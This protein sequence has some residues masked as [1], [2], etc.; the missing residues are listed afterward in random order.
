MNQIV[1]LT[2]LIGSE[3]VV[4]I[5]LFLLKNKGEYSQIQLT[6]KAGLA[7]A[8]AV[9]WLRKMVT[10]KILQLRKIGPTNLYT[11]NQDHKFVKIVKELNDE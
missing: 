6:K 4:N 8:T 9:K 11:L 2:E 3:K 5:V 10:S 1:Q 7:K